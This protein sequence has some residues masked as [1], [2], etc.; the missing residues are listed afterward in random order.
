MVDPTF[1]KFEEDDWVI[2]GGIVG[3]ERD[4]L[5]MIGLGNRNTLK[6]KE[7]EI[8]KTFKK[9]AIIIRRKKAGIGYDPDDELF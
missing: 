7:G 5:L 9:H 6:N 8:L 1:I 2:L 3:N 4:D